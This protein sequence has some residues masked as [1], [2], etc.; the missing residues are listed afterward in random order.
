MDVTGLAGQYRKIDYED[1]SQK[2]KI[3]SA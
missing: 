1:N 3:S 2:K